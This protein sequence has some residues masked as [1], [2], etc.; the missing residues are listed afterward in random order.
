MRVRVD[1]WW[2][3]GR[4]RAVLL[5][6]I[7][8]PL[9]DASS[10]WDPAWLDFLRT[11]GGEAEPGDVWVLRS[12]PGESGRSWA[13]DE[14]T[15]GWPIIGY[16]LTC[17]E[18]K[19]ED[20]IHLWDHATGC[21]ARFASGPCKNGGPSCWTWTGQPEDDTLTGQ[22]SLFMPTPGCGWHGYLRDGVM[23]PAG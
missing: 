12:A 18:T 5:G 4:K 15:A 16:G 3:A 13:E 23:V 9:D 2:E 1:R 10:A 6:A 17:P 19:C 20:G 8:N 7:P 11:P 21:P 14:V 22:P